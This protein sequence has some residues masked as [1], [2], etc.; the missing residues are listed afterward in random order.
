MTTTPPASPTRRLQ[1]RKREAIVQ[2][3]RAV[4]GRDGYA[5]ASIDAI[6]GE[7]GVST[8]TIYN[9]FAGKEQLFS[10]VLEASATQVADAFVDDVAGG[11]TGD[12]L[13]HDLRVLGRALVAQGTRFPEH[14]AMV[15]QINAE[16]PHFPAAVIETWQ[17]AGPRRVERELVRRLQEFAEKGLLRIDDPYRAGRHFRAV[18]ASEITTRSYAARIEL[19]EAQV[20]EMIASGVDAFLYGYAGRRQGT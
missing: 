1:P 2:G 7:A 5:R 20:D 3:A 4:F 16:A 18:V 19:T 11:V 6:A 15:R 13:E 8:R 9:H 10:F 14:F 12:D 17:E